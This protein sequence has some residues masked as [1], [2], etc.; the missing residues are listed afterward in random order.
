[1]RN[2][3]T[4]EWD[5]ETLDEYG[6]IQDHDFAERLIDLKGKEWRLV[7]VRDEG[8]ELNGLANRYWAYVE[9][10]KLPECFSNATNVVNIKVPQRFHKELSYNQPLI[11]N[12]EAFN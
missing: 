7:L 3:V 8:N 6:D 9:N 10:G 2:K 12:Y 5:L 4:Y 1:M 11:N